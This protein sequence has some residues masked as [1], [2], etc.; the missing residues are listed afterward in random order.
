MRR[1]GLASNVV[2]IGP[3]RQRQKLA[4]IESRT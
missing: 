1:L 2:L 3:D 4:A